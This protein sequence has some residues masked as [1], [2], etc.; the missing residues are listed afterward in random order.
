MTATRA[1]SQRRSGL[2]PVGGATNGVDL[3]LLA[4]I[5]T[6]RTRPRRAVI[7]TSQ[8]RLNCRWPPLRL[9]GCRFSRPRA[10]PVGSQRLCAT[11]TRRFYSAEALRAPEVNSGGLNR[12]P[13]TPPALDMSALRA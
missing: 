11:K 5:A 6:T 10:R 4:G 9:A 8:K 13:V 3:S 1:L 12:Q 2:N 7:T